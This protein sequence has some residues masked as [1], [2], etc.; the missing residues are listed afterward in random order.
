MNI[1]G[2]IIWLLCCALC[3]A[4]FA[5]VSLWARKRKTPMHF[6]S[7]EEIPPEKVIDIPAWNAAYAK[8]WGAY[9]VAFAVTGLMWLVSQGAAIAMMVLCCTVGIGALLAV[10]ARIRKKYMRQ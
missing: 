1:G 7:G 10:N 6:W 9:A 2:T 3:A 8:M 4:A 5:A